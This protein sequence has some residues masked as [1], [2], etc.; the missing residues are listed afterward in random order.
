MIFDANKLAQ[1]D[2]TCQPFVQAYLHQKSSLKIVLCNITFMSVLEV[3]K[4]TSSIKYCS[5]STVVLLNTK[6]YIAF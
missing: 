4:Q 5:Q 2:N 3:K 6:V 1:K